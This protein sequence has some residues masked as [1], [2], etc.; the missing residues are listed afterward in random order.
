MQVVFVT[1]SVKAYL[2]FVSEAFFKKKNFFLFVIN[3]CLIRY[4]FTLM[5][6]LTVDSISFYLGG[7]IQ[8]VGG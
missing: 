3:I 4:I 8:F 6:N 1:L 5:D 7:G 2:H